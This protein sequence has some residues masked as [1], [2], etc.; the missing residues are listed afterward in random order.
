MPFHATTPRVCEQCGSAFT[1]LVKRVNA[2]GGKYCRIACFR[3]ASRV[4][5]EIA[6]WTHVEKTETCWLWT[7]SRNE[8]GYG[9][10]TVRTGKR[11]KVFKAHRFSWALARGPIPDGAWVLHDCDVKACVRP[12]HLHLG[13]R[14]TN[15][16]EAVERGRIQSGG[17]HWT[18]RR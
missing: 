12:D 6:F 9:T 1:A 16:A 5:P 11:N 17:W 7:G 2:G 8:H 13:D 10:L 18:R 3:L 14:P 15:V 4:P